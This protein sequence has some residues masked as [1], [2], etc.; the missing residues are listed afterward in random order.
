[1]HFLKKSEVVTK[2]EY[3]IQNKANFLESKYETKTENKVNFLES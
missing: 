2:L 3:R 1:M